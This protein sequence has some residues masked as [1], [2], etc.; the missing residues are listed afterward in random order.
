MR[1]ITIRLYEID[2]LPTKEAKWVALNDHR[3]INVQ[4]EWWEG[5]EGL[6]DPSPWQLPW[7]NEQE[8]ELLEKV[9]DRRCLVTYSGFDLHLKSRALYFKDIEVHNEKLFLLMLG[10]PREIVDAVEISFSSHGHTIKQSVL[11]LWWHDTCADCGTRSSHKA[12][13]CSDVDLHQKHRPALALAEKRF[14]LKLLEAAEELQAFYDHLTSDEAVEETLK[15]RGI[16][17]TVDGEVSM[18]D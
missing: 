11:Q 18:Y 4:G 15:D 2:E 5:Y 17:F 9:R 8:R 13:A 12:C 16:E 6:L 14:G 1:T 7:L 10:V 3:E